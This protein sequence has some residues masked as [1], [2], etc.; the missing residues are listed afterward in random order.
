MARVE[1]VAVVL[2]EPASRPSR[3]VQVEREIELGRAA[4]G[5]RAGV[6]PSRPGRSRPGG[7]SCEREDHLEERR[8]GRRSRSGLQ[9]LD[10]LLEREVLVGV[11]AE[12]RLAHPARSSRKVGSP[13]RSSAQ[14]QGVDEEADQRLELGPRRGWPSGVPTTRSRLAGAA[15]EQRGERGEQGHEE[16]WRPRAA[17]RPRRAAAVRGIELPGA[18]PPP[19]EALDRRAA[20]GRCGSSRTAGAPASCCAPAGELARPAASPC[21]QPALPARVVRVLDRQLRQ[22]EA[23]AAADRAPPARA[24]G[25]RATSRPQT[26]WWTVRSRTW[27]SASEPQQGGAQQRPARQIEGPRAP[28]RAAEPRGLGLRGSA[29][30]PREVHHRQAAHAGWRITWTGSPSGSGEGRAQRLVAADDRGQAAPRAAGRRAALEAQRRAAG[31]RRGLPG[32]SWSRNQRRCWAKESGDGR[33]RS[34]GRIRSQRP[35]PSGAARRPS[36]SAAAQLGD[37]RLPR[38]ACA[39][40]ARRR[41]RSRTAGRGLRSRASEWPPRSKKSSWTPTRAPSAPRPDR[42]PAA[43]RRASRGARELRAAGAPPARAGRRR[44]TLPLGVSGRASQE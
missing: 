20:A 38:T 25:R 27:S 42:R 32:S 44:S 35:A 9:L 33:P 4:A 13:A 31:C 26:M 43:P 37:G 22:G 34:R 10:Q 23:P 3:V 11:G 1:E 14:H 2:Q 41:R 21:S 30:R 17:P 8:C 29:G 28:P 16:A 15:G 18:A 36:T 39:A 5:R 6:R 40:A 24:R 7:E 19:R 12:R